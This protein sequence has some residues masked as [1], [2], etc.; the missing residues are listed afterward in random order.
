[1]LP[2]E[3]RREVAGPPDWYF[4]PQLLGC[5]EWP[6]KSSG[7]PRASNGLT[8]TLS[9]VLSPPPLA[10]WVPRPSIGLTSDPMCDPA[11]VCF[12]PSHLECFLRPLKGWT[13]G[14]GMGGG[15]V[16]GGGSGGSGVSVV[17][18]ASDVSKLESALDV[19]DRHGYVNTSEVSLAAWL[20][21]RHATY[22]RGVM[23]DGCI[24]LLCGRRRGG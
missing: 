16:V 7:T 5:C 10:P 11:S 18:L 9:L 23:L 20:A 13:G 4:W 22:T 17:L 14:A 15:R 2:P 1:M 21:R 24:V 12:R 6:L 19:V 3:Q 8:V